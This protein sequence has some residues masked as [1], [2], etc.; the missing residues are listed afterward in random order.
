MTK[1]DDLED[2]LKRLEGYAV[3]E[4]TS[5]EQLW[6]QID[7]RTEDAHSGKRRRL[8]PVVGAAAGI[9]LLIG[10]YFWIAAHNTVSFDVPAGKQVVRELPGGSKVYINAGSTLSYRE[11]LLNQTRRIALQGEA[12]F[13]VTAGKPFQ[14]KANGWTISVTG[15]RF[16]VRIRPHRKE[17]ACYAGS[18]AVEAEGKPAR[19]LRAGQKLELIAGKLQINAMDKAQ[20]QAGWR[21]GRFAFS[22]IPLKEVWNAL[23]RQFAVKIVFS[24]NAERLYSGSFSNNSL[25]QALKN[26]CKP[27]ELDYHVAADGQTVHIE[28]K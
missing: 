18:V 15:T 28:E 27:M 1:K 9:A 26:V 3:P 5:K 7:A 14:V 6:E 20:K 24:G 17:V 23:Q 10:L 2:Y 25:E 16:N 21:Q 19:D 11:P 13:E 22:N 8:Y 4:G 12:F